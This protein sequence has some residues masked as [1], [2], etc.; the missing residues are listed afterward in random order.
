MTSLNDK[1][2]T[3]MGL[4]TSSASYTL[5]PT[6][7]SSEIVTSPVPEDVEECQCTVSE[8]ENILTAPSGGMVMLPGEPYDLVWPGIYLGEE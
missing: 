2:S 8:L 6:V 3:E 1:L 5:Q 7:T 4:T